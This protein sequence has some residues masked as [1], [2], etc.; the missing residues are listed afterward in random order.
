MLSFIDNN[1]VQDIFNSNEFKG[2]LLSKRW[3]G[4]KSALSNLEFKINLNYFEILSERILLT[5][6][7][8]QKLEYKKSY[9]LP[10][11]YYEKIQEILE[12]NEISNKKKILTLTVNTFSKKIVLNIEGEQKIFTVNLVEGEYCL[13]FWKK[14]LFDKDISESFP[15][16]S[17]DLTLYTEQ[18]QDEANMKKVQNL[19]E[20]SL[21]PDRYSL[22][23]TQ[24]GGGNTTNTLFL[25]SILNNRM[26]DQEPITYVL[27]SY[28]EYL[29]SLEPTTLFV[30]VKNS[31][32]NAPK[33]Y[34]TIKLRDKE[35]IGILEDVPNVGNLGNIYWNE[36]NNMVNNVFKDINGNY[37]QLSE[38]SNISQII[39]ENCYETLKVSAEI[40]NYIKR[41]H[42]SL[43]YP[44]REEYNLESV[45]SNKYLASYTEKLNSMISE[46]QNTMNLQTES[47]F[48]NLPKISS[49]LI[50]IKDI[51]QSFQDE[52]KETKINI[53]PVHQDLH[54]EQILYNK[55]DDQYQY[56][57]IDFEGDPQLTFTE[58]KGKFPIEKDLASF[59]RALS[60]IKFNTFLKF[61]EKK[62]IRK[63]KYEVPEEIL[64]NIIFRRAARPINK[65]LDVVLNV[66]NIW[67]S[68]L[69]GKILK[70]L[71]AHYTLI[72]YFY[73]ERALH[74]LNYEMLFR[75]SKIIVPILGLKEIIDKS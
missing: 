31:F 54:M 16:R 1:L 29:E 53:Q 10:L 9:F 13:F 41:L 5:V 49:I 60:Y 43:I 67:E 34:G 7:D 55:I 74:E 27:K 44:E 69:I 68:K 22:S 36:L 18:F 39:K 12:P 15:S 37:S 51:I 70:N 32:P 61:I 64:Y 4:D 20:T 45:E 33:I 56:Y 46:L 26:P 8:I 2:W 28:K 62:V 6:I 19:I 47:S 21:Y 17:L 63:D 48:F 59:L 11:I 65:T 52:F 57:F 25:L 35:T 30:L 38:K 14:I 58:K 66:L 3:F 75:P 24:L 50:D 72:T 42:E 71:N 40:G 73:I 23:L